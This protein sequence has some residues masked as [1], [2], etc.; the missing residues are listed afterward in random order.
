MM[1]KRKESRKRRN[2]KLKDMLLAEP[3]GASDRGLAL[4]LVELQPCSTPSYGSETLD[5]LPC[6]NLNSL[7]CAAD[8][9]RDLIGLKANMCRF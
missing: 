8:S 4:S 2:E 9:T 7:R 6:F 3:H 1:K 5:R